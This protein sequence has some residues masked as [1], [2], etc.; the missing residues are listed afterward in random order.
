MRRPALLAALGL[1]A[2]GLIVIPASA[3]S[4]AA[5]IVGRWERVNT[6]QELV[7]ALK[8]AGLGPTAPAM[9]A[10]NG[11]VPGSAWQLARRK[12][13]CK[14]AVPRRHSH[15]FT[16]TGQFGSLDW[17]RMQVDDGQYRADRQT[18]NIGDG[19]F[20]YRIADGKLSLT[21]VI[22]AKLKRQALAHPLRFSVAGWMVSVAFAGHTWKRVPCAGWC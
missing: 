21:P 19:T 4:Q 17:N 16:A 10:G 6:C 9:L 18:L 15:F 3:S 20:R 13:L 22:S 12:N 11:Y 7:A 8:Q 5:A 14:G 1:I 2:A